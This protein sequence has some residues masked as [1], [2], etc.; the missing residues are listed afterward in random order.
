MEEA[1]FL[2]KFA[3]K[4]TIVHRRDEFRASQI[5]LDRA[6]ANDEDR[7]HHERTSS[8]RCSARTARST[9]VRLRDL[10]T[11]ETTEIPPHG[12][13]RRDRPRPEHEALPRPARPR[14]GRLPRHEARIDRDEHPRRLRCGRRRRPHYRQAVTA[15]GSGCMAALDAERF[16]AARE[17]IRRRRSPRRAPRPRPPRSSRPPRAVPSPRWRGRWID[18]LDP[19]EE[20]LREARSATTSTRRAGAAPAPRLSGGDSRGRRV[21]SHGDYVLGLAARGRSPCRRKTASSTRRSTSSSPRDADPDR[22]QDAGRRAAV[23]PRP[24]RASSAT[25]TR[26]A[27]PGMIAYHLV[28]EIAERYLDLID[29]L[30]EEIDELEDHVDDWP[31]EQI[32]RRHLASSGTTCSTSGGRS[33]R[34]A[35]R[36]ARS[37]TTGSSSRRGHS[38]SARRRARRFADATTSCC[39]RPRRSSSSRDLLAGVRDYH[40]AK[41]ANDQNEVMKRLTVIASLLLVPTF[42]VG[43]YGQNFEHMPELHWSSGYAWSLGPDRRRRPSPSSRS[44]AARRWI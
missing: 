32:R 22:A 15:A 14:R 43:L 20:E 24:R 30:D 42:I 9:G 40:Q 16:L 18:L 23:R 29:D 31:A 26:R 27:P 39:A 3:T 33:R 13:L 35:T 8:T 44:S 38:F 25:C 17:G 2:T 10:K 11:G 12:P 36:C 7:V 19:D 37:S 1:T 21:E 6:R 41:I 34:R 5:M 4:V 28:D